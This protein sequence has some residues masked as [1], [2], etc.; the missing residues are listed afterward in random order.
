[1]KY[2]EITFKPRQGVVN[3]INIKKIIKIGWKALSDFR[4]FKKQMK[5]DKKNNN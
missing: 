3:S 2:E 1:M 5:K 4:K